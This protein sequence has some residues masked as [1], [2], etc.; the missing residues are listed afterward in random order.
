MTANTYKPEQITALY[1]RLSQEDA[2][3]GDSNSIVNQELICKGWF[4][5]SNTYDCGSFVVN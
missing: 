2:L 3:D 4:L 5:P 1:A